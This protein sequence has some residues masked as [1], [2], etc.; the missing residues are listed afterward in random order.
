MDQKL[1]STIF[2]VILMINNVFC[3]TNSFIKLS[4]SDNIGKPFLEFNQFNQHTKLSE[5]KLPSKNLESFL[6]K[7]NRGGDHC[8]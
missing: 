5:D 4:Y 1:H 7:E 6:L 8:G 2:S 3:K